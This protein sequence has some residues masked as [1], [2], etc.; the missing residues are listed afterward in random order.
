MYAPIV[1]SSALEYWLHCS[2]LKNPSY[3][4]MPYIS[5]SKNTSTSIEKDCLTAF[6][7]NNDLTKPVHIMVPQASMRHQGSLFTC[8]VGSGH[9]PKNSFILLDDAVVIVSPEMCFL[10]A[11]TTHTIPELV[12]L[13][14]NL[15]S[16]FIL[17]KDEEY[18]QYSREQIT[19][20]SAI[21]SFLKKAGDFPGIKKAR[22]AIK[23][24][25][26][27]SNSPMES[28]LATISCLP[29][30]YGGYALY[31]PRLNFEITL[32]ADGA[33][34]LKR[35]TCLGDLVWP[36]HMTD[37]EYD[38]NATHLSIDQ[39]ARDK[40]RFNALTLTGYKVISLT[41]DQLRSLS[42]ID[43]IFFLIRRSLNMQARRERFNQ[44]RDTRLRTIRK[45]LYG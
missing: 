29:I 41:S 6:I 23:Y 1:G 16:I 11:A 33:E 25:S 22:I 32:S 21:E 9:F 7:R 34:I 27:R 20:V 3:V 30:H 45:I 2:S 19:S 24:A 43:R 5:D 44:H 36:E 13:A 37:V 35:K 15:C 42:E 26:D 17:D 14:C 40:A 12:L 8:H 39:H 18:G 28:K 38:S 31:K 4:S 10:Q